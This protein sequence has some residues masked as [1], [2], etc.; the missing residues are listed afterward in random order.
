M[1]MD[2]YLESEVAI[3]V[4]ATAAVFSPPVRRVLRRGAVYGLTGL[5]IARDALVSFGRGVG[6]GVQQAATAAGAAVQQAGERVA[7]AGARAR[8]GAGA[9][10]SEA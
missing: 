4:A 9:A 8:D 10:E 1:A 5:L 6:S 2:D 7:D 3:A